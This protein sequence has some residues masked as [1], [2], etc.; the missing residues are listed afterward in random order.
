[1]TLKQSAIAMSATLTGV[2]VLGKCNDETSALQVIT[3]LALIIGAT[4]YTNIVTST[5][6]K[7]NK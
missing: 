3:G 2:F 6:V 1:M 5:K 7:D 4:I